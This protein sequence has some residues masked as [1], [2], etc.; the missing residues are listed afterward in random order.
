M[1]TGRFSL[2]SLARYTVLMPPRPS[3]ARISYDPRR[4]PAFKSDTGGLTGFYR[5]LRGFQRF[6]DEEEIRE[7]R[8]EVDRGV[9]V[10]DELRSD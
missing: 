5:L 3:R 1:A 9:E 8:A 6:V 4:S 10:V 7:Q 2:V